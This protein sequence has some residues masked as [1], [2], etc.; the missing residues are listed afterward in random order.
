MQENWYT[1]LLDRNATIENNQIAHFG[2]PVAE[3]Q[4]AQS[5]TILTDLSHYG[6]LRFAGE[7]AQTFL[8]NQLSCDVRDVK[9]QQ[10]RHGSYCTPKGRVLANF[11]VLQRNDDWLLRLPADLC[12][13]IQKRLSMFILRSRVAVDDC[14]D[15]WVR[16]GVAGPQAKM[17]VETVTG[18]GLDACNDSSLCTMHST[19]A[20]V[21]CHA[22]DRME[23]LTDEIRAREWWQ[24]ISE[25][26]SP[27]GTDCWHWR[28]ICA[29]I[30]MVT[31]A[32]QEEFLPQMIN[33]DLIGGVSFKKGCYPGQEIVARTQYLGKLKRRMYLAHVMTEN[34]VAAGDD[35]F[36]ADVS[37]QSCGTIVNAVS[38]PDG[39][40][41]V[42]AVIQKA[43]VATGKIYLHNPGGPELKIGTLPYTLD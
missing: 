11:I 31:T 30:P 15:A 24:K 1:F 33:L 16:I 26:A 19:T 29:G 21:I 25:K 22:P 35:V 5:G 27:I 8:Q 37:D 41:D 39:G 12:A 32:T 4:Y 9:P 34:T 10:G 17:L 3:L 36:C 23:I 7:D 2:D 14:S 38:A 18:F 43:S 13:S 20:S 40:Y 42:L 6:L 28:E